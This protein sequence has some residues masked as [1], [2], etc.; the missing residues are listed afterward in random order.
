MI[1]LGIDPG[2][3]CPSAVM[4]ED[5]GRD[6]PRILYARAF[7]SECRRFPAT[8][9][10][11]E[12]CCRIADVIYCHLEPELPSRDLLAVAIEGASFG[13]GKMGSASM[14]QMA[15][16]RQAL[17]GEFKPSAQAVFAASPKSAKLALTGR[18][19][20]HKTQMIGQAFLL[21]SGTELHP[22]FEAARKR[23]AEGKS[24]K[25]STEAIAD[26]L[27]VAMAGAA[28]GRKVAIGAIK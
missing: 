7:A 3:V 5:Q 28:I 8:M 25:P 16:I 15:C 9:L 14:E 17:Y 18:G 21:T 27:G 1:V 11:W 20:A 22:M 4:I 13:S 10:L 24:P 2:L 19:N 23:I 26:A 12:R 6:M